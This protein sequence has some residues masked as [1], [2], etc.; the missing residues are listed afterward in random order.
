MLFFLLKNRRLSVQ[1]F[2]GLLLVLGA[3]PNGSEGLKCYKCKDKKDKQCKDTELKDCPVSNCLF[4]Q[5]VDGHIVK[6]CGGS[7]A[8]KECFVE[9]KGTPKEYSQCICDTEFCNENADK[10]GLKTTGT[11]K[12]G[13]GGTNKSTS[14]DKL[15]LAILMTSSIYYGY[16]RGGGMVAS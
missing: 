2:L 12:T 9:D 11:G 10:A 5:G 3:L 14:N 7:L 4:L 16:I 8:I 6:D 1:L 15:I 13:A